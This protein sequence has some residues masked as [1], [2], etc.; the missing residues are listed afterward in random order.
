M[1][2]TM[3]VLEKGAEFLFRES[4]C[5]NIY[6]LCV[7]ESFTFSIITFLWREGEVFVISTSGYYS[8]KESVNLA[9]KS[10]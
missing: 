6:Y 9:D 3:P 2:F 8:I 7:F 5:I 4:F 10:L 1:S